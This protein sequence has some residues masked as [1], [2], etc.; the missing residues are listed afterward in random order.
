M[1]HVLI[2]YIKYFTDYIFRTVPDL[3]H[4]FGAQQILQGPREQRL[5][6]IL[7]GDLDSTCFDN[8]WSFCMYLTYG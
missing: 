5:S 2:I 3:Q 8:F 1:V 7:E 6:R 4:R